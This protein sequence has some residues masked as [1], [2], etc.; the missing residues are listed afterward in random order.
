MMVIIAIIIMLICMSMMSSSVA[1]MTAVVAL[2][3]MTFYYFAFARKKNTGSGDNGAVGS[4]NSTATGNESFGGKHNKSVDAEVIILPKPVDEV[5][6]EDI[7]IISPGY[8]NIPV[9]TIIEEPISAA[10]CDRRG[11]FDASIDNGGMAHEYPIANRGVKALT[12]EKDPTEAYPWGSNQSYT[13]CYPGP[14][15]ELNGCNMNDY[16]GIDEANT[17]QVQLRT[18]DKRV[19]DGHI[20]KN[21]NYYKRH[22]GKELDE[23]ENK[24]WWGNDEY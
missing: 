11:Y 22:F 20:T 9:T 12:G 3:S 1:L 23:S 17:R 15:R 2:L 21:A 19:I 24:R 7:R 16:M 5:Y 6:E 4:T 18:R 8:V 14:N 13:D 10:E